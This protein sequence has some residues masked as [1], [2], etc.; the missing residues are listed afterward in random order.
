MAG[1]DEGRAG[2]AEQAEH[3]RRGDRLQHHARPGEAVVPGLVILV[4]SHARGSPRAPLVDRAHLA[5]P[6]SCLTSELLSFVTGVSARAI[7]DCT[8]K[9]IV[10]RCVYAGSKDERPV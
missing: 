5:P 4:E 1:D 6:R 10:F 9:Y 3:R 7:P 8:A 2:E